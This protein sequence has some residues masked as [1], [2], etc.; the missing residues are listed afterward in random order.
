[1]SSLNTMIKFAFMIMLVCVSLSEQLEKRPSWAV[2]RSLD[3]ADES[4]SAESWYIQQQQQQ[5]HQNADKRPSWAVG[6]DLS[7]LADENEVAKRIIEFKRGWNSIHNIH[8]DEYNTML[9]KNRAKRPSIGRTR[10]VSSH[11]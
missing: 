2:G 7:D 11:H 8:N 10:S 4:N 9:N 3:S 1:M 5:Q 6:R